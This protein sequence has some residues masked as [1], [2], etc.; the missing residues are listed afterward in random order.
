MMKGELYKKDLE[1]YEEAKKVFGDNDHLETYRD[2]NDEYIALRR[3]M[4]RD[5]IQIFK[6]DGEVAF[7]NNV[8]EPKPF[9]G[10][11]SCT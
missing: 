11:S 3:G 7:F 9:R 10:E 4:D 8:M 2:E 6:L 5:C 1:F